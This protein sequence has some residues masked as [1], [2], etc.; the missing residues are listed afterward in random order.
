M[1]TKTTVLLQSLCNSSITHMLTIALSLSQTT[2][3]VQETRMDC[4]NPTWR[5]LDVTR[6]EYAP[7][8]LCSLAQ[9]SPQGTTMN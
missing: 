7:G 6:L 4:Y 5:N 3:F 2:F 8:N 1:S 9:W